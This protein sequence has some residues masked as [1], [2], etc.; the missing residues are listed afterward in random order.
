MLFSL[1]SK[2]F[3]EIIPRILFHSIFWFIYLVLPHINAY[4]DHDIKRMMYLRE[5]F[6]VP[7]SA[8][9]FFYFNTEVLA[10]YFLRRKRIPAYIGS[11]I[12][13]IFLFMLVQWKIKALVI[14]QHPVRL[15]DFRTVV[16]VLF[17]ISMSSIYSLLIYLQ[18]QNKEYTDLKEEKLVSELQ[19]LRSQI[20]PHFIF[21]VLNGLVYLIRTD[22]KSAEN[23][24]IKLSKLIRYM[25]YESD[26]HQVP[27][28]KEIDY[29]R[30]YIELQEVRFGEDVAISFEVNGHF[31]HESIEPMLLIPFVENAFKHGVGLL[32]DPIIRVELQSEADQ[33]VFRVTNKIAPETAEHKDQQ[34]GIGLK[35]V[36]RRLE[37]LYPNAHTL[38]VTQDNQYFYVTLHL[39]SKNK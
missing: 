23:M 19:F 22:A 17:I 6:W 1:R 16:P 8:I 37:L 32:N 3:V 7:L 12:G 2:H 36:K 10:T 29:L 4:V 13:L 35:N 26:N 30:N 34:S 28:T 38:E 15:F 27:L 33:I 5:T 24:T 11:L 18:T 20:S 14:D 25:L 39:T 21:N 9:P 31:S